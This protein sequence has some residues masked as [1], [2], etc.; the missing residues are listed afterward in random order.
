MMIVNKNLLTRYGVLIGTSYIFNLI[1]RIG[2]RHDQP[3]V[4]L[5]TFAFR[6][7]YNK[8]MKKEFCYYYHTH[9]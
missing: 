8:R 2:F 7:S 4:D 1:L 3:N 5:M 9:S 6:F